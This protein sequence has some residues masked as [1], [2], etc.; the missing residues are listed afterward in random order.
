VA[1]KREIKDEKEGDE[2]DTKREAKDEK[3]GSFGLKKNVSDVSP[4]SSL[5]PTDLRYDGPVWYKTAKRKVS[6][7]TR[8]TIQ[9]TDKKVPHNIF[10]WP[11]LNSL[12]G[13][14]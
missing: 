1:N 8:N 3:F 14:I 6:D 10:A 9:W 12:S 5:D 2:K 7:G 11:F 4:G 13:G